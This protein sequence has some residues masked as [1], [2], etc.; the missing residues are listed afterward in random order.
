ME[1]KANTKQL[2]MFLEEN[3]HYPYSFS[4]WNCRNFANKLWESIKDDA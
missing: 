3:K 2:K 4:T 1:V